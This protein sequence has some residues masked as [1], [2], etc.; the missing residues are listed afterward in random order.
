MLEEVVGTECIDVDILAH[1]H[2]LRPS[3]VVESNVV[4]EELGNANDV[5]FRGFLTSRADLQVSRG[6][7]AMCQL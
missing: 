1:R 4:V 2:E 3:Q 7:N 5:A 6:L